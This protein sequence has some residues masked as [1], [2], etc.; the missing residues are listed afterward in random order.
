MTAAEADMGMPSARPAC[1]GALAPVDAFLAIMIKPDAQPKDEK[2]P[3]NFRGSGF[4]RNSEPR[5]NSK[6]DGIVGSFRC[7]RRPDDRAPIN[8]KLT[9]AGDSR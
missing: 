2:D 8:V 5:V 3:H 1:A 6:N 4:L 7:R 9:L